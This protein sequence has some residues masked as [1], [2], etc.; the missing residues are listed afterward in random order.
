MYWSNCKIQRTN[1]KIYKSINS[2]CFDWNIKTLWILSKWEKKIITMEYQKML[3]MMNSFQ[4]ILVLTRTKYLKNS[5]FFLLI[6]LHEPLSTLKPIIFK[7]TFFINR[8]NVFLW[9][10]LW[11]IDTVYCADAIWY[12]FLLLYYIRYSLAFIRLDSLCL[13]SS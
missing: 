10:G 9:D 7:N 1:K 5:I 2:K 12:I 4:N 3:I 6:V 8:W 11:N 13:E